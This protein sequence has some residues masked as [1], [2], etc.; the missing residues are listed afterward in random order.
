VKSSATKMNTCVNPI[1]RDIDDLPSRLKSR[2]G[3]R[4]T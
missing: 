1:S 3:D 2:K 4:P